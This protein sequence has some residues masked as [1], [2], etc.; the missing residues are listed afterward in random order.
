MTGMVG[1][2][3]GG[4][5]GGGR[6]ASI[7]S[8]KAPPGALLDLD[9]EHNRW[10]VNGVDQSGPVPTTYDVTGLL[11]TNFHVFLDATSASSWSIT[12]YPFSITAATTAERCAIRRTDA[13]S[14]THVAFASGVNQSQLALLW[15]NSTRWQVACGWKQDKFRFIRKGNTSVAQKTAGTMPGP[16]T[17]LTVGSDLAGANPW[18]GTIH[19]LVI[20]ASDFLNAELAAHAD[21]HLNTIQGNYSWWV[22]PLVSKR[23]G[24]LYFGLMDMAGNQKACRVRNNVLEQFTVFSGHVVDDHSCISHNFVSERLAELYSGHNDD[25]ALRFR[26]SSDASPLNLG[27]EVVISDVGGT[28]TSYAQLFVYGTSLFAITQNTNRDWDIYR[29]DDF[30]TN[31]TRKKRIFG[32]ASVGTPAQWYIAG[33]DIGGGVIRFV[34]QHHPTNTQNIIYMFDVNLET[35]DVSSGGSTLGNLDGGSNGVPIVTDSNV[36]VLRTPASSRSQRLMD[37][38]DDGSHA[39]LVDFVNADFSDANLI[40]FDVVAKTGKTVVSGIGAAL[41]D[42]YFP[43][44]NFD[45]TRPGELVVLGITTP[46]SVSTLSRYVSTD[47][48]DTWTPTVLIAASGGTSGKLMR[49]FSPSGAQSGDD[50]FLPQGSYTS[51]TNWSSVIILPDYP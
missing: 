46:S 37:L 24:W 5:A 43:G 39:L 34:G 29:S 1:R 26:I 21:S 20:W 18:N 14:I 23:N 15:S 41:Y 13:T 42:S 27:S 17:T 36:N 33:T 50:P 38:S 49:V 22:R 44:A 10:A 16:L 8:R 30:G 11:N 28:D 31:W 4:F 19:R 45:R 47:G 48:G 9:Y 40:Y 2:L 12:Q 25:G 7:A 51:F 6:G 35:G 32:G 3:M